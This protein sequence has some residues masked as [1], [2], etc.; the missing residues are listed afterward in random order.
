MNKKIILTIMVLSILISFIPT[1]AF[2]RNWN[3]WMYQDPYPTSNTLLAVK[4]VTPQKGWVAG[5]AGTILYTEDGGDTWEAQES[6]TEQ[7]LSSIFF[8][9][10]KTGWA[11]GEM[12]IVIHTNDGGKSWATQAQTELFFLK[13]L[14]VNEQEGWAATHEG[15]HHTTDGGKKWARRDTEITGTS[16]NIF[17]IN[18]K[19]GW[20]LAGG[21]VYSTMDGGEKWN[22]SALP[23]S[24]YPVFGAPGSVVSAP[25]MGGERGDVYFTDDRNGWAVVG[26]GL[27]FHTNDGGKTWVNQLH[28]G[29]LSYGLSRLAFIDQ[30]RGCAGGSSLLCTED[31]G[32]TWNE[33]LGVKP[34]S[35]E[36]IDE[37][38]V[39]LQAI[40]FASPTFALAVGND[41]QIWK[42]ESGGK[43]WKLASRRDECGHLVFFLN[44]N[45]GWFYRRSDNAAALCRTDD[46]GR[47]RQKQ[48]VGMNV[49][50]LFFTDVST[51]WAIGTIEERNQQKKLEK[52]YGV[53]K[54]TA[55]GGK[56]WTTQFREL[57]GKSLFGTDL[58]GVN[59][60]SAD[61]GWVVGSAG[62][63]LHTTDGGKHWERQ[64]SGSSQFDLHDIRFND[65]K[66][67]WIAGIKYNDGW[68]GVILH[69]EDGGNHWKMQYSIKDIGFTGLFF[70]DK[71]SGWVTGEDEQE[72]GSGWIFHTDDG[73]IAWKKEELGYVGNSDPIFL[74]IKR[75]VISTDKG[76]VV[77]TT[78]GGK[79]WKRMRKPIGKKNPWH[80]SELFEVERKSK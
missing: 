45:T 68:T 57:R 49:L 62:L 61:T 34:G 64:K 33:K 32:K 55:D 31:G 74:D 12:G 66:N 28:T 26:F 70:F 60:V 42:T 4:F 21:A 16:A 1:M 11:V 51:G 8:V 6:G 14:F 41:G 78:D 24:D 48:D 50:G 36:R 5:E 67:G 73:G 2:A 43:S 72:G 46:G 38:L 44:K 56:T 7:F 20:V 54:Y 22:K 18:P 71:K 23:R 76:W 59:F 58:L 77:I 65:P 79:T 37:F 63:I 30:R 53:I 29:P 13:V 19:T 27:I 17:F 75:G 10:E 3:G 69:T 52:V 35:S 25:D 47:T 9:N 40:S 39:Q 15:I 80:V